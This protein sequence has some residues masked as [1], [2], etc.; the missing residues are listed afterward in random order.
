M[1]DRQKYLNWF[2]QLRRERKLFAL[3]ACL[4]LL[5]GMFQPITRTHSVGLDGLSIICLT[6]DGALQDK[7]TGKLPPSGQHDCPF[8]IAGHFCGG[9]PALAKILVAGSPLFGLPMVRTL[10]N[11]AGL[12]DPLWHLRP[13]AAPPSIR[14][15]PA[16]V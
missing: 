3:V 9:A 5:L 12:H 11:L 6:H 4:A 10:T 1:E 14:A 15:P 16:S 7:A 8:C 13:S 2:E